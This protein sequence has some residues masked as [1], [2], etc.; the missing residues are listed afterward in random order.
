MLPHLSH[1]KRLSNDLADLQKEFVAAGDTAG[2]E[3]VAR[4][5]LRLGEQLTRGPGSMT[6]IGEL[7][8]IAVEANLVRN[9]P[10]DTPYDFLGGDAA[11]FQA[12]LKQRRADIR[13][14]GGQFDAWLRQASEAD[15]LDYFDLWAKHG[16]RT[17]L[18]WVKEQAEDPAP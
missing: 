2:A 17:A 8:G 10:Q 16:E 1:L 15:V 9:L 5:G 14:L 12:D 13:P 7:V 3:Y 18:L 6:L 4:M 11:K